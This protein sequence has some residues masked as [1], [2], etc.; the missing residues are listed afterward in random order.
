MELYEGTMTA[1]A[2]RRYTDDPVSDEDI[3]AC[4]AASMQAPSGGNSQPWQFVVLRD[5][6]RTQAV[7][8]IYLRAFERW[9]AAQRAQMPAFRSESE[10]ASFERGLKASRTLAENLSSAQAL[11]L[12][13][14]PMITLGIEDDRGMIDIGPLYASVYPAV[15]N[16]MLAARSLGIGSVLTT[17]WWGEQAALRAEIGH[18]RPLRSGSADPDGISGW[19]VRSG[20]SPTPRSDNTLG[21]MGREAAG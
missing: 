7:A 10:E 4:L 11:V 12:F 1:R 21:H 5:D 18:S 9:E 15:Q 3:E 19:L 8:S 20:P 16:F 14:A 13:V 2:I 17:V 6:S